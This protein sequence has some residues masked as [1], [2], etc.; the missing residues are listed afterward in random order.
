[1]KSIRRDEE[2]LASVI[3]VVLVV[4]VV[5][6]V[7]IGIWF[8]LSPSGLVSSCPSSI[9]SSG[10]AT[11]NFVVQVTLSAT[12]PCFSQTVITPSM[13]FLGGGPGGPTPPG[14][15]IVSGSYEATVSLA[16]TYPNGKSYLWNSANAPTTLSSEKFNVGACNILTGTPG[17][18]SVSWV[19]YGTGPLGAY[20]VIGSGQV[21]L[22]GSS[23]ST[24]WTFATNGHI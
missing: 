24:Q 4:L 21:N 5:A 16:I 11:G 12:A 15:S 13:A 23:A 18:G 2:G 7:A 22:V 14:G 10:T 9:C 1:M 6:A 8:V 20:S 3:V 19:F 17:F